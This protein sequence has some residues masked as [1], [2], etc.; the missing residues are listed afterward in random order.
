MKKLL[1]IIFALCILG[2]LQAQQE[3]ILTKYMYNSLFFNPAYAGRNGYNTGSL[4]LQYRNQW[5]H[6]DG[7]PK[8]LMAS[9]E[10]SLFQNRLGVGFNFASEKIGVDNRND[11]NANIAYRI[12][13]NEENFIAGGI[14]AGY[15]A[16][17]TDFSL[18]NIKDAGD[19][20][21]QG[22]INYGLLSLGA[23]VYYHR[24][25]LYA[26][27]SVPAMAVVAFT[28]KGVGNKAQHFYFQM[29]TMT[30]DEY[31]RVRIEPSILVKF[32]E[33]TQVQFTLGINTWFT[34][35]FAI[36]AHYRTEDAFALSA[37]FHITDHFRIAAAYD[38]TVSPIRKYSDNSIEFMMGYLFEKPQNNRRIRSIRHQGRF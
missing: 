35:R 3:I 38:L 31:S 12:P 25:G 27:F 34:D 13:I 36:G 4:C 10:A 23:G 5:L 22:A 7:A 1:S 19:I 2:S 16:Y 24:D 37:E 15:S 9:G 33:A 6:L 14:R 11:I 28:N 29:G 20:Y 21:D 8:T 26:G 17:N 18:L 30:G 32:Q